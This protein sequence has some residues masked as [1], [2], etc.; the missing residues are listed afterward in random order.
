M[1]KSAV[2]KPQNKA[3]SPF[4]HFHRLKIALRI[5][6]LQIFYAKS[7]GQKWLQAGLISTKPQLHLSERPLTQPKSTRKS[8]SKSVRMFIFYIKTLKYTTKAGLFKLK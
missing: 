1:K 3:A 7:N 8:C 4:S 2:Q 5:G 6:N